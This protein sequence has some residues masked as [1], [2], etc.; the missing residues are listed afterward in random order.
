MTANCSLKQP[1]QNGGM[2]I[3]VRYRIAAIVTIL[4]QADAPAIAEAR[5]T[6][7]ADVTGAACQNAKQPLAL[8]RYLLCRA[9]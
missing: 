7:A 2:A 9:I 1:A 5:L 3:L 6:G 4:Q 8:F